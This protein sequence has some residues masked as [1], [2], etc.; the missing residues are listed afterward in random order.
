[1]KSWKTTLA[2][3]LVALGTSLTQ[4]SDK[5]LQTIGAILTPVGS[6]LL[7]LSARDNNVTSEKAGA[8]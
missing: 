7:G 1:M 3:I 2:G 8:K 6:L 5:T 4:S